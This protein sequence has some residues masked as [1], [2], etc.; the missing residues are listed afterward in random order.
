MRILVMEDT[1]SGATESC[2]LL[3]RLGYEIAERRPFAGEV[4]AAM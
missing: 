3:E 2:A 1:P 4:L